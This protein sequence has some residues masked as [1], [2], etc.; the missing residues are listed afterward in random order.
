M[1]HAADSGKKT[2]HNNRYMDI[3]AATAADLECLKSYLKT[4]N[5]GYCEHAK[6]KISINPISK[7]T[8]KQ[9]DII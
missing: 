1:K 4:N 5:Y 9:A 7:T 8:Q 2:K 3:N 6:M